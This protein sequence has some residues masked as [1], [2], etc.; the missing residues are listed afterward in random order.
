MLV[1]ILHTTLGL[2]VIGPQIDEYHEQHQYMLELI[3]QNPL[4]LHHFRRL[5]PVTFHL[6]Q[7]L[8]IYFVSL[9]KHLFLEVCAQ[10]WCKG[11]TT[12]IIQMNSKSFLFEFQL[13]QSVHFL[14][15][16]VAI[17]F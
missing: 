15:V 6:V 14:Y 7:F 9:H 1:F 16:F 8:H 10:F 13:D 5:D 12:P 17:V 2:T 11:I 3:G 4:S